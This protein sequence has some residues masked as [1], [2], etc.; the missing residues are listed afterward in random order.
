MG[1]QGKT[2][3]ALILEERLQAIFELLKQ[4]N[5]KIVLLKEIEGITLELIPGNTLGK[6]EEE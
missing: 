6:D 1:Y 3:Q 5:G 2:Y 4:E